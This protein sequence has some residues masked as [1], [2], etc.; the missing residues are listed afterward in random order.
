MYFIFLIFCCLDSHG[1]QKRKV[2]TYFTPVFMPKN[3]EVCTP[4][5]MHKN[6]EVCTP[7]LMPKNQEVSTPV[8]MPKNLEV[9]FLPLVLV[10]K[11]LRW[12]VFYPCFVTQE[13]RIP[14]FYPCLYTL[15]RLFG[16][17]S[18]FELV[19]AERPFPHLQ[20]LFLR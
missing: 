12:S 17:M 16:M 15:F 14:V 7:V 11:N 9:C 2:C 20:S 13:L 10:P 5:F 1:L 4:V 3:Q 6:Q 18:G 19:N 8:F